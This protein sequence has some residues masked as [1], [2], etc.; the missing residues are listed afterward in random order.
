MSRLE[1]RGH[2]GKRI[3]HVKSVCKNQHLSSGLYQTYEAGSDWLGNL[4]CEKKRFTAVL[5]KKTF[6]EIEEEESCQGYKRAGDAVAGVYSFHF[7]SLE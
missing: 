6:M 7:K 3:K 4:V 1:C 5:F 2:D